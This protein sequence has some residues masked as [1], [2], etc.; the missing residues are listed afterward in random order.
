MIFSL[1]SIPSILP[2]LCVQ[3]GLKDMAEKEAFAAGR[4]NGKSEVGDC[5]NAAYT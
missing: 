4:D 2:M 3:A 1:T 5:N